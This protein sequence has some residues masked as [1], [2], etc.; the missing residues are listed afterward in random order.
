MR[1]RLDEI[2]EEEYRIR[3]WRESA[4]TG[5]WDGATRRVAERAFRHGV[6]RA[7][8]EP[9]DPF[10]P[11]EPIRPAPAEIPTDWLSLK[12]ETYPRR[13]GE[14]R[15]HCE[16]MNGDE[17][18]TRHLYHDGR[19]WTCSGHDRRSGWGRRKPNP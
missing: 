7:Y 9:G 4:D 6:E 13:K 10:P 3:A 5:S 1:T 11:H 8:G 19:D 15:S 12:R 17:S 2:V 14:R 16:W 18:Y